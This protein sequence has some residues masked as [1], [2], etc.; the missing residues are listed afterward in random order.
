M[1]AL[2]LSMVTKSLRKVG[3][4]NESESAECQ[5][6]SG[7]CVEKLPSNCGRSGL[8]HRSFSPGIVVSFI[9]LRREI[10]HLGARPILVFTLPGT[11]ESQFQRLE[12]SRGLY[13][14]LRLNGKRAYHR[15]TARE[16]FRI[17]PE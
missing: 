3:F 16:F 12:N 4:S 17:S 13:Q 14:L 5:G 9:T 7:G 11:S 15:R 6:P 2:T 10:T 8:S 1:S